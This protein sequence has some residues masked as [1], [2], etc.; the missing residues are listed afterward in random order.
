LRTSNDVKTAELNVH[1]DRSIVDVFEQVR[2][3]VRLLVRA[4]R[5]SRGDRNIPRLS[6]QAPDLFV[7]LSQVPDSAMPHDRRRIDHPHQIAMSEILAAMMRAARS[8]AEK[9]AATRLAK[10]TRKH[11]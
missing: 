4:R 9:K 3:G 10:R 8:L 1:H 6:S 2:R 5:Q 11:K 7:D